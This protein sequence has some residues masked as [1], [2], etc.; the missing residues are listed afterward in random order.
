MKKRD[1]FNE[2]LR[3]TVA[4]KEIELQVEMQNITHEIRKHLKGAGI[5]DVFFRE[6]RLNADAEK[7]NILVLNIFEPGPRN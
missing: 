2:L 4:E 3:T 1:E 7:D 6:C 5:K